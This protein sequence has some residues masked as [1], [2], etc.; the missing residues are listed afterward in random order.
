MSLELHPPTSQRESHPKNLK[1]PPISFMFSSMFP[2]SAQ[3]IRNGTGFLK[4]GALK[5]PFTAANRSDL[6]R[7]RATSSFCPL[8]L[9]SDTRTGVN[10]GCDVTVH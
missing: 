5:P 8:L 2:T 10:L 7:L 9:T 3:K 6:Y 4:P 1:P